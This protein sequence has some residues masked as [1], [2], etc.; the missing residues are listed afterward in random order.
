MQ[1]EAFWNVVVS[2]RPVE[3]LPSGS[4]LYLFKKGIQP[5]WED[6]QNTEV[7][8]AA[9]VLG[10]RKRCASNRTEAHI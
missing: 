9:S 8:T 10:V 4:T 3:K 2:L 6:P 1:A 7:R 5:M